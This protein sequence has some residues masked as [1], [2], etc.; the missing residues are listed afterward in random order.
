[1]TRALIVLAVLLGACTPP[2]PDPAAVARAQAAADAWQAS[3]AQQAVALTAGF[4]QTNPFVD[5][6]VRANPWPCARAVVAAGGLLGLGPM[7]PCY[8]DALLRQNAA[9]VTGVP[10]FFRGRP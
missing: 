5:P 4:L 1:M 7:P 8:A 3:Q 6:A 10:V 2:R 9:T